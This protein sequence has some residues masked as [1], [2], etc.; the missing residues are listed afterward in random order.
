MWDSYLNSNYHSLQVAI[1]RNV[2][3]LVLKGAYTWSKALNMADDEGWAGVAWDEDDVFERNRARAGYD[4]THMFNMGFVYELPFLKNNR[5]AA[6]TALGNWQVSGVTS[7]YTGVPRT[8]FAHPGSLNAQSAWQTADQVSP[9]VKLGGVGPG[10]P[11]Y[12]PSSFAAVTDQRFG[13]TG[14]NILDGPGVT[15]LDLSIFKNFPISEEA[16]AEFRVEFFNIT[17]TPQFGNFQGSLHRGA[18]MEIRSTTPFTERNIRIGL[19]FEF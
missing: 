15:N 6:G 16:K 1:N 19:R 13:N 12:D 17:N 4:R 3:G 18:F 11:Y 2:G 14:R 7:L 9:V 8:I 5:T 10:Q